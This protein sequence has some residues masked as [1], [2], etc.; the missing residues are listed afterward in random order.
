MDELGNKW[1]PLSPITI[2]KRRVTP[3]DYRKYDLAPKG[4]RGL[5]T[6]KQDEIWRGIYAR[7]LAELGNDPARK[8]DAAK[9][10]WAIL[11]SRYGARV[12]WRVLASRKVQILIDTG[13]LY[14]SM[15]QGEML[16]GQYVPPAEQ[17]FRITISGRSMIVELDT[18]VPY[19]DEVD[20]DRPLF[21]PGSEKW[22][23]LIADML[24]SFY[25]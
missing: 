23:S 10:A 3:E 1:K 17:L 4:G 19:A 24:G 7:R 11:K 25:A 16:D 20:R 21:P 15:R 13:R 14:N 9:R 18:L 8:A 5:L 22:L 2:A 12:K 6:A